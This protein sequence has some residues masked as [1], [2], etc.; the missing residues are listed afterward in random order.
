MFDNLRFKL[1]NRLIK[2][3]SLFFVLGDRAFYVN[4]IMID[5]E[6]KEIILQWS[7]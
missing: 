7:N 2:N 3:Y 4:D 6:M 1:I 5:P